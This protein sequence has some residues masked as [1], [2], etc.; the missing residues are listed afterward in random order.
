MKDSVEIERIDAFVFRYPTAHPVVTS[1]GVMYDRPAVLIR[2]QSID[3]CFG[4]GEIFANWPAA[5]A[6]HRA[7]LLMHD[8]ADLVLGIPVA[9]PDAMFTKLE[10][11]TRIRA[12]QSGEPGPFRQVIAGLDIALSDLFARRAGQPLRRRLTE[13]ASDSVPVYASG[14]NIRDGDEHIAAARKAGFTAFKVKVGFDHDADAAK[15]LALE[16]HLTPGEA[17]FADANQAWDLDQATRFLN[18]LVGSGIGWLEEPMAVDAPVSDW[19]Q[20]AAMSPIPLAGGE[21]LAGLTEFSDAIASAALSIIQPDVAKWGGITGCRQVAL[22]AV[23]AG[24]TYC[25]HFLG[26]GIGLVASAHLLAAIGGDGRLEVDVNTNPL[27]DLLA[28]PAATL[29]GGTLQMSEEPGLGIEA[30]PKDVAEF[31]TLAVTRKSRTRVGLHGNE[32]V[33]AG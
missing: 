10:R 3:G 27:R 28:E 4:W 26:S 29:R 32:Q 19:L 12:I 24:R 30:I 9:S 15:V 16:Q 14:I 6:E 23:A 22:R 31:Q 5:G 1:F 2:L 17:L 11:E 13:A 7:N 33:S 18:H 25:P 20:L 21:N 8:V